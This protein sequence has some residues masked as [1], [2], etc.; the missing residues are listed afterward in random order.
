M[1][2]LNIEIDV[3]EKQLWINRRMYRADSFEYKFPGVAQ[4]SKGGSSKK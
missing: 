2:L 3:F 1:M 4:V